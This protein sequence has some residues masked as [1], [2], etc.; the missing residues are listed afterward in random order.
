MVDGLSITILLTILNITR[1]HIFLSNMLLN[2]NEVLHTQVK[3]KKT[4]LFC[5]QHI[6]SF[7]KKTWV[8]QAGNYFIYLFLFYTN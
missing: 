8:G 6:F 7:L 2:S 1:I 5:S 3:E 4:G